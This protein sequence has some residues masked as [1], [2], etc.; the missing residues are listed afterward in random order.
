MTLFLNVYLI[1]YT[2]TLSSLFYLL[3][4]NVNINNVKSLSS[5]LCNINTTSDGVMTTRDL[6][7]KNDISAFWTLGN[8]NIK[9]R[10]VPEGSVAITFPIQNPIT[11]SFKIIHMAF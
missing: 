1:V 2:I 4:L 8:R 3:T 6:I 9:M 11:I 5:I 7:Y 10:V